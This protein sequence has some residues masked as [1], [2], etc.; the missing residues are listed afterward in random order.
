MTGWVNAG[1]YENI[2]PL[3]YMGQTPKNNNLGVHGQLLAFYFKGLPSE[4]NCFTI[5]IVRH[6]ECIPRSTMVDFITTLKP[7]HESNST[8]VAR[9]VANLDSALVSST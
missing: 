3:H 1:E 6:L 9:Q 7:R 4:K 5:E 8:Q 2:I